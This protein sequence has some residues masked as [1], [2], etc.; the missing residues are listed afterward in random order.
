LV[1]F[2]EGILHFCNVIAS[3]EPEDVPSRACIARVLVISVS[4]AA[5][6]MSLLGG[7]VD[8]RDSVML[9][10]LDDAVA[11]LVNAVGSWEGVR[12]SVQDRVLQPAIM[13]A[14]LQAFGAR[15][16][17]AALGV[18]ELASCMLDCLSRGGGGDPAAAAGGSSGR[19][20]DKALANLVRCR[21]D[22]ALPACMLR[23]RGDGV[24]HMVTTFG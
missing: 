10:W 24:F 2:L 14:W 23:T 22:A 17:G 7:A 21:P 3:N 20:A 19:G 4:V 6:V 13:L 5:G 16:T 11:Q 12:E 9:G 18:L 1:P 15:D 8:Q